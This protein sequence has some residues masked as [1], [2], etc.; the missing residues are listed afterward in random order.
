MTITI[1][2]A[3]PDHLNEVAVLFD[4]YRQW[5]GQKPN[6]DGA[7]DFLAARLEQSDSAI[8]LA[9][10]NVM[11]VGFTQLYPSFSS[12]AMRPIWILNDLFVVESA[13]KTGVARS[14]LKEAERFARET[15]AARLVLETAPD[16]QPAQALY[17]KLGWVK[18][19][20][21]IHYK[22]NL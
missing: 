14:L 5:Y 10:E 17:E 1:V 21:F 19:D 8:F 13:R 4:A 22:Y 12:I 6:H 15:N 2:R 20:E 18:D 11:A 3:T 16:N 7:R 9:L